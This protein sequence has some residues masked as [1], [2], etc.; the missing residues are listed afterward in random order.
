MLAQSSISSLTLCTLFN[1]LFFFH[2]SSETGLFSIEYLDDGH[3]AL[4]ASNDKYVNAQQN[5]R[6]FAVSNSVGD[7]EKFIIT[8]VNRPILVLKCDYG[9]VGFK[10]SGNPRLECNKASLE[11]IYLVQYE[12]ESL[13]GRYQLKGKKNLII[14]TPPRSNVDL[15]RPLSLTLKAITGLT[16]RASHRFI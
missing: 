5:G 6:L 14:I 8:V 11:Y 1:V 4:K 10:S 13:K 15:W 7:R 9:F 12:N 16:L 2:F 3:V